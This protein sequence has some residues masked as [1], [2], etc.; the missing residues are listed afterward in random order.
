MQLREILLYLKDKK[1][2]KPK[3]QRNGDRVPCHD[4]QQ[5]L[6]GVKKRFQPLV[7]NDVSRLMIC[8][9][10]IFSVTTCDSQDALEVMSVTY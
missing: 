2:K 3:D 4:E 10:V 1:G 5:R 7:D 6:L 8:L 9:R